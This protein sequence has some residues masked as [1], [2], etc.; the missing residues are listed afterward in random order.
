MIPIK[1][2]ALIQKPKKAGLI[3]SIVLQQKTKQIVNDLK[4]IIARTIVLPL[5]LNSKILKIYLMLK[6]Q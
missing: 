1:S 6:R 3:E 2:P 4:E 5:Q